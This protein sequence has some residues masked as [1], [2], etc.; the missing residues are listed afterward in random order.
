[1]NYWLHPEAAAEHKK[2]VAHYEEIQAGL[3]RRYHSEFQNALVLV[4]ASPDR[5]RIVVAP[6]IRRAMFKVF[7][8]DLVYR[9]VDGLV[10]VLAIAHHRRQ[11]GYWVARL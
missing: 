11:P 9:E 10:Q 5:S 8:F 2:Q 1:M 3:G 4:C 7:H 6:N